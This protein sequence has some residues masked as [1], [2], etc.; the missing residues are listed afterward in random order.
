MEYV[1]YLIAIMTY[2]YGGHQ[3]EVAVWFQAGQRS[4]CMPELETRVTR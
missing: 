2:R 1:N 3:K 4:A